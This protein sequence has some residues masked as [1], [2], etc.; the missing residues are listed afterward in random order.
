MVTLLKNNLVSLVSIVLLL[1]L[2]AFAFITMSS[3]AVAKQMDQIIGGAAQV[4]S[5]MTRPQNPATIEAEKKRVELFKVELDKGVVAVR[6]INGHKPLLEG[7]FPKPGSEMRRFE[8]KAAYASALDK[9]SSIVGGGDLPGPSDLQEAQEEID[10]LK[11]LEKEKLE[12]G[13]EAAAAIGEQP[14]PPGA[15]APVAPGTPPAAGGRPGAGGAA[16]GKES[17]EPKYNAKLRAQVK[18]ARSIRC[19]VGSGGRRSYHVSPIIRQNTPPDPDAM[20]FAQLGLWIQDDVFTAIG[21]VNERAAAALGAD[22][23]PSVQNLPVKRIDRID[24]QGYVTDKT[25]LAFPRDAGGEG[26]A[27]GGAA[28]GGGAGGGGA[29]L[30]AFG[31]ASGAGMSGNKSFTGRLSDNDFD[32]VRF[33][34]M[35]VGDQRDVLQVIDEITRTNLYQCIDVDYQQVDSKE[36]DEGYYYGTEPCVRARLVFEAYFTREIYD[37]LM[38]ESVRKLFAIPT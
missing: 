1:G 37:P 26:S 19:Y 7:V 28:G 4:T 30:G 16:G 9:L 13:G 15:A 3:D 8:F 25:I 24:I 14:P 11:E 35:F 27:G 38:P 34:L 2:L 32:V 20:W 33:E 29:G 31:G 10:E 6:A 17:N 5:L 12:S 21:K 36:R 18:Q 23:E 22:A